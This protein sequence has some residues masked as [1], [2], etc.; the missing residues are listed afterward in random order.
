MNFSLLKDSGYVF[1]WVTNLSYSPA[2]TFMENNGYVMTESITWVKLCIGGAKLKPTFGRGLKHV[3]EDCLVFRKMQRGVLVGIIANERKENNV[4]LSVPRMGSQKP[5]Q[6]YDTIE[7]MCN[8]GQGGFLEIFARPHNQR[9]GWVGIGNESIDWINPPKVKRTRGSRGPLRIP[10]GDQALNDESNMT[11]A[12][13]SDEQ[14]EG[15]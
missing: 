15:Q 11:D 4:I 12:E 5:D 7:G 8:E 10:A 3:K 14:A 2:I 9:E 6:I 13:P 1:M